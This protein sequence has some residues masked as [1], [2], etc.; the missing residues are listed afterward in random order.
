[1]VVEGD[2]ATLSFVM[3]DGTEGTL[4]MPAEVLG[5]G[6]MSVSTTVAV[7]C[8]PEC[9]S[10]EVQASR[11]NRDPFADLLELTR[12]LGPGDSFAYY[13]E[14]EPGRL[15]WDVDD[16]ILGA[17]TALI[18][19]GQLDDWAFDLVAEVRDDGWL[20]LAVTE[21]LELGLPGRDQTGLDLDFGE[22]FIAAQA[23]DCTAAH[24]TSPGPVGESGDWS[25]TM[26]LERELL[27]DIGGAES[28]VRAIAGEITG[29]VDTSR[30]QSSVTVVLPNGT[31]AQVSYPDTLDLAGMGL[32]M[33]VGVGWDVRPLAAS[34][35]SGDGCCGR[36]VTLLHEE[37]PALTAGLEVESE[38]RTADDRRAVVVSQT[39][40][41]TEELGIAGRVMAIDFSPWTA[42]VQL[43][44]A[45]SDA[46]MSDDELEVFAG[47]LSGELVDGQV[48]LSATAPLRLEPTDSPDVVFDDGVVSLAGRP[49]PAVGEP[50]HEAVGTAIY[51]A[52]DGFEACFSTAGMVMRFAD[53]VSLETIQAVE[54]ERIGSYKSPEFGAVVEYPDGWNLAEES[55]TPH[56]EV[57]GQGQVFAITTVEP[58]VGGH[59][60]AQW[61][62][63]AMRALGPNDALL[64]L[65]VLPSVPDPVPGPWD[66]SQVAIPDAPIPNSDIGHCVTGDPD[67]QPPLNYSSTVFTEGDTSYGLLFA[68]GHDLSPSR[69]DELEA[70]IGSISF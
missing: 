39:T 48:V 63:N 19:S 42:E 56:I 12:R 69:V 7:G 20:E 3:L 47:A 58:L 5:D 53:D 16:W 38:Y 8:V 10:T 66:P 28:T 31:R 54:V 35:G 45:S 26:C 22:S 25:A 36:S 46:A 21:P 30:G 43:L 24:E 17:P 9:G 64:Y 2:V 37:A 29:S 61:P 11:S 23:T 68:V 65:F 27:V 50:L 70:I 62:E 4:S 41:R 1:V 32:E 6:P 13:G 33:N 52:D 51:A 67:R 40:P 15:V 59:N 60:C 34:A 55:L 14:R 44:P 57:E 18:P 49:C